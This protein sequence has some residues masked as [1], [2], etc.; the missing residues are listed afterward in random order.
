MFGVIYYLV[1]SHLEE[2]R[3]SESN[4]NRAGKNLKGSLVLSL[5]VFSHWVLDLIV[6]VPD[7]QLIPGYELKVGLGLW[8]S[9]TWTVILESVIFVAGIY[10]YVKSTKA[11]NLRGSIGYWSLVAFLSFAYVMN[12]EGPPP[13]SIAAIGI[14]GMSQWLIIAWAYWVD[15]NR[16]SAVKEKVI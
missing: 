2:P 3:V 4:D 5:L 1:R 10:L 11:K 14:A 13:P 15:R 7:L 8:N 6:H 16:K 12:L 9:V